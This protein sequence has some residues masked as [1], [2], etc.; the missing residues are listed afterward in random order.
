MKAVVAEH[1]QVVIPKPLRDRLGIEEATVLEIREEG[2][3]I[4]MEKAEQAHPIE[5]LRGCLQLGMTTDAYLA[6]T[7][8][9]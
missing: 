8:G 5:A 4:V 1:G 9:R 6:A 3:R 7:R 2:G